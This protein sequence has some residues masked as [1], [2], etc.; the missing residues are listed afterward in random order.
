MLRRTVRIGLLDAAREGST[1]ALW[2][3][4]RGRLRELG[5]A[6]GKNLIIEDRYA[7]GAPG[8]LPALAAELV[9]LE[10]DLIVAYGTSETL[11]LM[12]LT[13]SIPIVFTETG[14]AVATGML[15]SLA[16]PGGNVTGQSSMYTVISAKWI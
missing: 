4:F 16:R 6:E 11:A 15:A 14:D 13:S 7:G 3:I 5:Y 12:K 8:S 2:R 10:P 9:G 1:V